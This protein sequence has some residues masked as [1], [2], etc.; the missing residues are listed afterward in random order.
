[1]EVVISAAGDEDVSHIASLRAWLDSAPTGPLWAL[2]QEPP[3][4][5][6]TLGPDIGTICAMIGA[7]EGLPPLIAWIKSWFT[8]KQDPPPVTL[9]IKIDAPKG[10]VTSKLGGGQEVSTGH[11]PN[12]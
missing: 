6:D 10:D 7:A 2:D 1:V 4:D 5:G 8:T 3:L 12:A 9:T 11:E